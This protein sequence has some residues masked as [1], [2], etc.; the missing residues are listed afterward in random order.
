M[1]KIAL[2]T[3][4]SLLFIGLAFADD[5]GMNAFGVSG[6]KYGGD[7]SLFGSNNDTNASNPNNATAN[8]SNDTMVP[9]I[10]A[11][12]GTMPQQNS[13]LNLN[14][15]QA[16]QF[17]TD[18]AEPMPKQNKYRRENKMSD[19][20]PFVSNVFIRTGLNLKKY[21][22]NL[23]QMPDSFAPDQNIPVPSNYLIGPGDSLKIQLWGAVNGDTNTK[24]SSNG[25]IFIPKLGEVPVTGVKS[26]ELDSYLK[27]RM[28]KIYRNFDVAVNISKV[29]SI[30]V[31]ISGMANQPGTYTLSSLSTLSIYLD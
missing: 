9:P 10:I 15:A 31:T 16:T 23:F 19:Y 3:I 27:K 7:N 21:G 17:S 25:T 12:S 30:Q 1:K 20:D 26:G 4:V 29:R 18:N 13:M 6:Q 22:S 2:V 28:G 8:S 11:S 5:S 14:K 24:V